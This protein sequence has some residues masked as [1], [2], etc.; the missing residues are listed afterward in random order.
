MVS[1][2]AFFVSATLIW[3]D[4]HERSTEKP[5]VKVPW[6]RAALVSFGSLFFTEWG[7]PGQI[8]AAALTLKSHSLYAVWLGDSHDNQRG[9]GNGAWSEA[10][11]STS[12]AHI[13]NN[14]FGVLF[15]TRSA[16][17]RWSLGSLRSRAGGEH[18]ALRGHFS[19]RNAARIANSQGSHFR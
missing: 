7:D 10:A 16:G 2:C 14:G 8:S 1:A 12:P 13:A 9:S 11:R 19:A 4:E 5:A 18:H 15:D 3:F 6:F 17:S